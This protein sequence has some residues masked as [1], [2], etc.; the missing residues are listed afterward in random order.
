MLN[1]LK[2]YEKLMIKALMIM[3]AIVLG[4]AT[5]DLGWVIIKDIIDPPFLI[6]SVEQLLDIFGLFMLVVIGIE[7]LGNCHED[8]HD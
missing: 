3:M 1:L 4:L 5:I 2:I 7:T 8:L 6:L